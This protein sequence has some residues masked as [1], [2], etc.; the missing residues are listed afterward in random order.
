MPALTCNHRIRRFDNCKHAVSGL[1]SEFVNGFELPL[2][3][4][5]T[6]IDRGPGRVKDVDRNLDEGNEMV[7]RIGCRGLHGDCAMRGICSG[8]GSD[9][10]ARCRVVVQCPAGDA[11]IDCSDIAARLLADDLVRIAPADLK[12]RTTIAQGSRLAEALMGP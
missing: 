8:A 3:R 11:R 1:Q 2:L 10:R 12:M 7:A 4:C 6:R 5:L 9:Y